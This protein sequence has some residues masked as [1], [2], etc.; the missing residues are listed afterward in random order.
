MGNLPELH[1]EEALIMVD[2]GR[3]K[4]EGIT[5]TCVHVLHGGI[6][7]PRLIHKYEAAR[8]LENKPPNY[9][10]TQLATSTHTVAHT[11]DLLVWYIPLQKSTNC[12]IP[13]NKCTGGGDRIL[14]LILV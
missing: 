6:I 12:H 14:S 4:A 8:P 2:P 13:L 10:L 5:Y 9:M 11:C 1:F 3:Y 7:T